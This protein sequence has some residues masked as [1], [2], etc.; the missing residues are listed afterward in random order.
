M[1]SPEGGKHY[2]AK[3]PV[4]RRIATESGLNPDSLTADQTRWIKELAD[5]E[6]SNGDFRRRTQGRGLLHGVLNP[7]E[8]KIATLDSFRKR[9]N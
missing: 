3:N 6:A 2:R 1:G 5:R 7:G 8:S 9:K 4:H